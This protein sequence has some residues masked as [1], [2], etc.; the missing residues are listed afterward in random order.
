[1]ML[2]HL[3][4]GHE[5]SVSF[6]VHN[7]HHLFH[8]REIFCQILI[9]LL[10]SPVG[11]PHLFS[12]VLPLEDNLWTDTRAVEEEEEEQGL[13]CVPHNLRKHFPRYF[14]F[15]LLFVTLWK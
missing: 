9:N 11:S 4:A 6:A 10:P 7:V 3:T 8:F 13:L 14:S 5:S 12:Q 2:A 15:F 1:M